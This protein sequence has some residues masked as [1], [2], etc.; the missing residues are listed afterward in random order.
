MTENQ[1][2]KSLEA[3]LWTA[4][5]KLLP[6]LDAAV[7]K[8]VVL[9]IIFLKYV[10]DSFE[11]RR[12]ELRIAFANPE[13]DYYLGDDIEEDIIKEEL[14]NRDYY[15][16]KNVFWVPR[17]ARWHY[18][19]DN[20]RLSLG[21]PLPLGGEF[22]GAGILIDDA[23]AL[24]EAENP[25]LKKILKK[26]FSQLQIDQAKLA[27]LLDLIATI[28]FHYDGM[29]SK[30]ILGHV[31]EYFLGQFAA[32]EGKKGGQFYTPK[33]IVN[34]MVEMV[35]PFKGRVYDPA[36]GSGGFF[37]SSEKFIEEHSG[38][39]GD[40]SV[41]GQ[42][43]NPTTWRLAAMNM[44][45]RG[46]DFNFGKEPADTF[47]KDQHPDLRA[48][49]VLANPPFNMKEWWDGSLDGD[50]RWKYGKP[51]EGNA[52]FAWMQ[53]MLHH[54]SPNGVVGLVL[55]NGSLS[56]NT[57]GEKEVREAIIKADLVEAIVALPSQLFSNTQIPA[58]IWILN[59]NKAQKGKSLFIDARQV[60]YMLDRKQR[61][62]SDNDIHEL[63]NV[64][65]KWRKNNGYENVAGKYYEA[66]TEEIAKHEYIL[67]PGRYVGAV[68]VEDDG[69]SFSEK[70]QGLTALL[71]EQFAESAK[72]EKQIRN[73]LSELG[74]EL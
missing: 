62:F 25:K 5:N 68:D 27:D 55:S 48:D 23:M 50:S 14:E 67:T 54:T 52:N 56:T 2:L 30:D 73:N 72:L 10:S 45:I 63:A 74:Y 59:K 32:A 64:F 34:L 70:M 58:C 36:M 15:T 18:L 29:K 1:F 46:I 47:T 51:C 4:A 43:S 42:E 24:I 6:S 65:H 39:I 19:Q 57:A 20:I 17:A 13:H 71:A 22:K 44:A 38:K 66:S 31:Y 40:I 37:I 41:Y 16:E 61:A 11:T 7:Y 33:S 26:D 3:K 21:A 53:H 8:H 28:P 69:V 60:G 49:F 9:G 35:E 12:E